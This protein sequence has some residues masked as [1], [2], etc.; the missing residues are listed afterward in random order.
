MNATTGDMKE[1]VD[2]KREGSSQDGD[3][4]IA[5]HDGPNHIE[6]GEEGISSSG[7]EGASQI[8]SDD[9]VKDTNND[10]GWHSPSKRH[11]FRSKESNA[12][13]GKDVVDK[14]GRSVAQNY[15]GAQQHWKYGREPV[16]QTNKQTFGGGKAT[17]AASTDTLNPKKGY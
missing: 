9:L 8:P 7:V 14:G 11:T 1:V 15:K 6:L 3:V 2:V 17:V 13:K 12:S 5:T 4:V 10:G 16:Q